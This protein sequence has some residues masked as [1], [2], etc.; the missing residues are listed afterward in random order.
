ML[1]YQGKLVTEEDLRKDGWKCLCHFMAGEYIWEKN[2]NRILYRRSL[3]KIVVTPNGKE[4][5]I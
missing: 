4:E 5:V 2:G 3:N 1:I